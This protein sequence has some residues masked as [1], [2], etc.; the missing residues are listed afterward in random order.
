M[1]PVPFAVRA[2]VLAL[3]ATAPLWLSSFRTLLLTEILILGLFA[4]S[5]DLL[6]GYSGLLSL[7]HAGYLGV[8][9]FGAALIAKHVTANA[10]VQIGV[11]TGAAAIVAAATGIV[12]VRS[13]GAYFLMLTLAFG[14]LLFLLA[15]N[16]NSVT[17]GSNGISGFARPAL[18]AGHSGSL[19][20]I[21]N[22]YW[23]VLCAFLVGYVLLKL[24]VGSPFGRALAGIRENEA[25]MSSLGY[26]VPLYKL[27]VFSLA[28]GLAGYAGALAVQQQRVALPDPMSFDQWSSLAVIVLIIGGQRSLLGPVIGAGVYYVVNDQLSSL[29]SSHWPMLLGAVF[30]LVVYLLPG[31][32]V[33]I[34]R[35]VRSR[36]LDRMRTGAPPAAAESAT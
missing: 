30:M 18:G 8:G 26:N 25:R 15:F 16:W 22:V 23:Y 2:V 21:D 17:G 32:L 27:A 7:G 33:G 10:F 11:A 31:G 9:S 34:G 13:R 5:L 36:L 28:G 3:L 20:T 14:Q 12:A 6:I 19:L 35:T 29:L 4:A 1:R 24:I